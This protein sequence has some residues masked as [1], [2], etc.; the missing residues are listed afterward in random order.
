MSEDLSKNYAGLKQDLL[1]SGVVESVASASSPVTGIYMHTGLEDWP[2][3]NAGEQALNVGGIS[4]SDNYFKT[5]GMQLLR[6]QDFSS[7]WS[8]DTSNVIINEAAV[9]MMGL[10]NPINQM[11]T[12][13]NISGPARIIG[14]IKNALMESPFTPV[15]P[16]VFTHGRGGNYI[17]YRL[18]AHAKTQ[19]AIQ[20]IT[21]IFDSYN[22]AYPFSYHF[23]DE[24]YNQKFNLESLVGKLA[25]IFAALAIFISCLGL[26]GL[27]AYLAEQR[28][29]EI[30]IRKV[31]G[32]SIAQ[33]WLMLSKDFILLV[34][35]SCLLASPVAWYF[36]QNWLQ[37]YD[38]RIT[39]GPG[40][41]LIS[42]ITAIGITLVTISFQAIKAALA[43]PVKSLRME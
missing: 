34:L 4:V 6:G 10:K 3:K 1:N 32:A 29:R 12:Y 8:S 36:L 2:G 27:A 42:G 7:N 37:K 9:S 16:A 30:G 23:V 5:V 25:G 21:K 39:I 33:V 13:R 15:A 43:N 22:P 40:V 18:S 20:K 41:F 24:E 19:E 14:I 31:L 11:V 38:Y 26:F 35:I 28:T 17:I